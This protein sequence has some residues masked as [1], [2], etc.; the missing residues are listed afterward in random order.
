MARWNLGFANNRWLAAKHGLLFP[1][2]LATFL[3]LLPAIGS[4]GYFGFL[5]DLWLANASWFA[6]FLAR[7]LVMVCCG[8]SDALVLR[9]Y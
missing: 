1:S 4:L 6:N 8:Y 9:C 7:S 2:G 3:I 5:P